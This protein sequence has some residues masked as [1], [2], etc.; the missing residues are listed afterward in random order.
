MRV[1]TVIILG[2]LFFTTSQSIAQDTLKPPLKYSVFLAG[3]VSS[4]GFYGAV[5]AKIKRKNL[6]LSLAYLIDYSKA[7]FPV[8]GPFGFGLSLSYFPNYTDKKII[9]QYINTDYRLIFHK[10]YCTYDCSV[11]YNKTDE[12]NIGYG[13]S[14]RILNK[15]S[16]SNSINVGWYTESLYS[17]RTS[18]TIINYGVNTLIKTRLNF[19]F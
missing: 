2:I 5:G 1:C 12:T 19:H 10:R 9:S 7:E 16:L 8:N 18:K 3:D 6:E 11:K 15:L 4:I 13:V 17:D 14:I